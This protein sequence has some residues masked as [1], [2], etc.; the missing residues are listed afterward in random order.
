LVTAVRCSV[1][2]NIPCDLRTISHSAG[3]V[4]DDLGLLL[5]LREK[6]RGNCSGT[7]SAYCILEV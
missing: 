5:L 1:I 2:D 7:M 3:S 6:V 4:N